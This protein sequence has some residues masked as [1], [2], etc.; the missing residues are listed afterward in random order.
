M[1]PQNLLYNLK[2]LAL[3]LNWKYQ[4][5]N[6]VQ[7]ATVCA[8]LWAI[9]TQIGG[10]LLEHIYQNI[11]QLRKRAPT[12]PNQR[13]YMKLT[14]FILVWH[15]FLSSTRTGTFC[16]HVHQWSSILADWQ[17][18]SFG[19]CN[20]W[21]MIRCDV[22]WHTILGEITQQ[23]HFYALNTPKNIALIFSNSSHHCFHKL[24]CLISKSFNLIENLAPA[25]QRVVY[26]LSTR[27]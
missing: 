15:T 24:K 13:V 1:D 23:R 25:I 11:E 17:L 26:C 2:Y 22:M 6:L 8:F 18:L 7:F 21:N 20:K 4:T 12:A 3:N 5:N 10:R 19:T 27:T 9:S 16:R 14:L